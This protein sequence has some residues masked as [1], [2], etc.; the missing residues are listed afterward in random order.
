MERAPVAGPSHLGDQE[1]D[2][3]DCGD[4]SLNQWLKKRARRNEREGAS[5]TYV[6]C[7]GC[8][9]IG[10]YA[11]AAGSVALSAAPGRVRRNMPDP[12]PV[13]VI[14]RLAVDRGWQ[15]Q[16]LG[17]AL[18]A[19]AVKRTLSAAGIAGIRA[20]LVHAISDDARRFYAERG[21]VASPAA[22]M[23]MMISLKDAAAN[24]E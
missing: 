13:M 3:F 15:G 19:D 14:G 20:I 1:L 18:L 10:Y 7:V 17:S 11:L 5:R 9:V 22:P 2:A 4:E 21:F 16:H 12:V 8:R 23:T 6:V 24:L